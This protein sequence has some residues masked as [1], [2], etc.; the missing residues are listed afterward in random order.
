M[1]A[2]NFF[3]PEYKSFP[4]Q[5]GDMLASQSNGQF[6]LTRIL[7]VDK[8]FLKQGQ[9]I[10]IQGQIFIAPEDDFLLIIS[11][12]IGNKFNTIEDVAK[13]V[14][15]RT[16]NVEAGHIP[17]RTSGILKGPIYH[18]GNYPIAENELSGYYEW[19]KLFRAGQAGIF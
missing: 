9:A 13:A 19:E 3:P 12:A 10:N 18:V 17:Q 14:K 8:Y 1:K 4:F 16:W 6:R 11:I 15:D 7:K 5:E 2:G